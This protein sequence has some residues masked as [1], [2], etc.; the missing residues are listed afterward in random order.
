[1]GIAVGIV[2]QAAITSGGP[3]QDFTVAGMGTPKAAVFVLTTAV[4]NATSQAGAGI[5]FGITDGVRQFCITASAQNATNL[6]S[7][8][9]QRKSNTRCIT[10]LDH[11]GTVLAEATFSTWDP[12]GV[13]GVRIN[14][15][16]LPSVAVLV[17]VHLFAGT[18]LL[19]Y[20][21]D[22]LASG[23]FAVPDTV[24]TDPNFQPDQLMMIGNGTST[25]DSTSAGAVMQIGFADRGAVITQGASSWISSNAVSLSASANVVSTLYVSPQPTLAYAIAITAF[26]IQGF[27]ATAKIA[28]SALRYPYL[29]LSYG[30]AAAHWVGVVNSPTSNATQTETAPGFK[31]QFVLQLPTGAVSPADTI[32]TSSGLGAGSYGISAF[33]ATK[34]FTSSISD[35]DGDANMITGSFSSD[36]F[37]C[38][39]DSQ[40]LNPN[41]HVATIVDLVSGN[42][43]IS[44]G[45]QLFYNVNVLQTTI[46]KWAS[47]AIGESSVGGP[48]PGAAALQ[49]DATTTGVA[50]V[51][52]AG[53]AALS[54]AAT[55]IGLG[56]VIYAGRAALDTTATELGTATVFRNGLAVLNTAST[57]S[58]I[59]Q[60]I[61]QA[62][63]ALP[64]SATLDGLGTVIHAGSAVLDV[65]LDVVPVPKVIHTGV[66]V[67][68]TAFSINAVG[69]A[70][71][72]A[73][74]APASSATTVGIAQ[75]TYAGSATL[76][77]S[78]TFAG[79]ASVARNGLSLCA[80][81]AAFSGIGTMIRGGIALLDSLFSL[82]STA[83]SNI[84]NGQSQV[85][86]A[87][88]TIGAGQLNY[89]GSSTLNTLA[90]LAATGQATHRGLATLNTIA[91][92]DGVA[93]ITHNAIAVLNTTATVSGL[94]T[95]IY[96]GSAA[97]N[98]NS[99]AITTGKMIYAGLSALSVVGSVSGV[100]VG[101]RNGN[102]NL[103]TGATFDGMAQVEHR[104]L[105]VINSASTFSGIAMGLRNALA[106]LPS[107][108]TTDGI[109]R[110]VYAASSALTA[111][112]TCN[113]IGAAVYAAKATADGVFVCSGYST[114][115]R[116]GLAVLDAGFTLVPAAPLA[117]WNFVGAARRYLAAENPGI[118]YGMEVYMRATAGTVNARLYN[119]TDGGMVAGS[120]LSTQ[121]A[122]FDRL[123]TA[124]LPLLD[125]KV[126]RA[127]LALS[128]NSSGEA[129]SA[130]PVE[131]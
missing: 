102:A 76:N 10:L 65:V 21:G 43:F 88:T 3:T 67:M 129:L 32:K 107:T 44:T 66:D 61:R 103:A 31:P 2:R 100:P 122:T 9:R 1:M 101:F 14:W 78:A 85:D 25:Y 99:T 124:A 75:M 30:G 87:F 51:I 19:A 104:A 93:R 48:Q 12:G 105:S 97:L 89:A 68:D 62:Q 109:G 77:T 29:A 42:P 86:A 90:T 127:Q 55:T 112:A 15:T 111:D 118:T 47:L 58:G 18:N 5:A 16:V 131:L 73:L 74:A 22:F 84:R 8:T 38:R 115:I 39:S 28:A 126:Y 49:T 82:V 79:A 64:T 60:L 6:D 24:V 20:A 37:R 46:R 70:I 106:L 96:A 35:D 130:V 110:V 40:T 80:A 117:M 95:A 50:R 108:V 123:R 13:N 23:N 17:T 121:S 27:T 91:T 54:T 113:A 34:V 11:T 26:S 41:L 119:E 56:R 81:S 83:G 4:T 116:T 59:A 57:Y 94:G 53:V 36:D 52:Y 120:L 128:P 45:W 72:N 92:T 7:I 71:R 33:T 98:T 63:S 114:V 69:I 125:D